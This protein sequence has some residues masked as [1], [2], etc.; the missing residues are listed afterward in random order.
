MLPTTA[1]QIAS[2][3]GGELLGSPDSTITEISTD[4]R[5]IPPG[6]LFVPLKGGNFDGHDY[7]DM[8]LDKG[9]AAVICARLP[10][11]VRADRA[12]I[13]VSDTKRALRDLASWYRGKFDIPVVQITGSMGKTTLKELL[14]GILSQ[15]YNTLKTPGN[16][17]GDIGAPLTLLSLLP[18]IGRAH[19]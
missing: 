11:T 17:N 19:V 16:L 12:Y 8:A 15:R 13:R 4:S 6:A 10:E 18:E 5:T 2:A 3:T 14:A 1:L 7:I 9:A